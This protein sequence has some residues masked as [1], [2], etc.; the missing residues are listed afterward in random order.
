MAKTRTLLTR[1]D[2]VVEDRAIECFGSRGQSARRSTIG[3][4]GFR[5]P[6]RVIVGENDAGA[7]ML[8]GVGDDVAKGEASPAFISIMT[9]QVNA[10][11]AAIDVGNP[12]TFS[13]GITFGE[14]ARKE[15]LGGGW[16]VDLQREFG[17]L[18]PHSR[19]RMSEEQ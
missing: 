3:G 19:R 1:E 14:A 16:A 18:I 12:Q 10:L 8:R 4:A 7:A 17:T 2:Q 9:G 13:G 6:T 5:V 11:R 15:G